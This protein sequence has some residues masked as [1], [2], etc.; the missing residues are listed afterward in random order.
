MFFNRVL[1][2][3][4]VTLVA[5]AIVGFVSGYSWIKFQPEAWTLEVELIPASPTKYKELVRTVV[6]DHYQISAKQ[7]VANTP[8]S[9]D[10]TN[11]LFRKF[12]YFL[13]S[14][15]RREEYVSEMPISEK[16]CASEALDSIKMFEL[17]TQVPY[18]P[19]YRIS[20]TATCIKV[21]TYLTG[22]FKKA[23]VDVL[24][25]SVKSELRAIRDAAILDYTTT[26]QLQQQLKNESIGLES[27]DRITVTAYAKGAQNTKPQNTQKPN[28]S[29]SLIMQYEYLSARSRV[30]R[31]IDEKV[32]Y[33]EEYIEMLL[34][35]DETTKTAPDSEWDTD[36]LIESSVVF[37]SSKDTNFRLS[38]LYGFGL[39][40]LLVMGVTLLLTIKEEFA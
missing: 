27:D 38:L 31:E 8:V 35:T 23:R 1:F 12:K 32:Q 5:L 14:Q 39:S 3:Y 17:D 24:R 28:S 9:M 7:Y 25:E 18:L 21:S 11:Y 40:S 2:K 6:T 36:W 20:S 4:W 26:L 37:S 13:S 34:A 22:F 29:A 10:T 30:I 15:S 33:L 19:S 16:K